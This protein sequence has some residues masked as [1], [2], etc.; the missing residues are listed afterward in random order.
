VAAILCDNSL[1]SNSLNGE[2]LPFNL[3]AGIYSDLNL[4]LPIKGEVNELVY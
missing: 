2:K 1:I 3:T 4:I